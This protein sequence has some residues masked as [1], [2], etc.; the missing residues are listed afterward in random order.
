[1]FRCSHLRLVPRCTISFRSV[2]DSRDLKQFN[3][4]QYTAKH[5]EIAKKSGSEAGRA[6]FHLIPNDVV[7]IIHINTQI[8]AFGHEG[9]MAEAI[10]FFK[11]L[12]REPDQRTV[13]KLVIG[14]TKMRDTKSA[15]TLI[16]DIEPIFNTVREKGLLGTKEY[17]IIVGAYLKM[18]V[19]ENK[20]NT[21]LEMFQKDITTYNTLLKN[22]IDND[23]EEQIKKIIA[24]IDEDPNVERD[25]YTYGTLST[26][27]A[28]TADYYKVLMLLRQ[29]KQTGIEPS[30]IT[31]SNEITALCGTNRLKEAKEL[32]DS[33]PELK[34][35]V[36]SVLLK[37]CSHYENINNMII[38]VLEE[39]EQFKN[40]LDFVTL[41]T[42]IS[43]YPK[44]ALAHKAEA[45]LAT[46]ERQ[47]GV[48]PDIFTYSPLVIHF[49]KSNQFEEAEKLLERMFQEKIY[50]NSEL[51]MYIIE[52]YRNGG[53]EERLHSKL[54]E[55]K[56]KYS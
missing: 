29:M 24:Q 36:V 45:L 20:I 3:A 28:K 47:H 1:M 37:G 13:V 52:C 2:H 32:Y 6:F 55:W 30:E 16:Q 56:N 9:R 34:H 38:Q 54:L 4:K 10:A 42:M 41:N 51:M 23:D 14:L 26:Y 31:L 8:S 33:K 15:V 22:A 27:Y 19:P 44:V 11:S 25:S 21:L 49:A 12:K 39:A 40:K 50:P 46:M 43:W 7:N 53:E 35:K 48:K 17:N 5:L 18:G